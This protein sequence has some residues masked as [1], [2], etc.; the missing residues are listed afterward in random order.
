M[1][2]RTG[3]YTFGVALNSFVLTAQHI[4][5]VYVRVVRF[6]YSG[7]DFPYMT[8]QYQEDGQRFR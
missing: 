8:G 7:H 1:T 2:C 6:N 5:C 4:S 3:E